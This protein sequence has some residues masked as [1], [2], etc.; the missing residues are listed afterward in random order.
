MVVEVEKVGWGIMCERLDNRARDEVAGGVPSNTFW[1]L[2]FVR[3][4]LLDLKDRGEK[5]NNL[6]QVLDQK[7]LE[8][9]GTIQY[10]ARR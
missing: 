7:Y 3:P 4:I 8:A 2:W 5:G 10:E 9:S 1:A 6:L